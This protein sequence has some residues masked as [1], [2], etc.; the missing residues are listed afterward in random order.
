MRKPKGF[1]L[2]ELLVVIAVIVLLMALL[3]PTLQQVRKEA[4]GVL[5]RS[6]LYEWGF[7][8]SMYAGDHNDRFFDDG[9]VVI[10][11]L[12]DINDVR[13]CPMAM[14]HKDRADDPWALAGV[15][16]RFGGKFSAWTH[17]YPGRATI[18]H[19]YGINDWIRDTRHEYFW[20]TPGAKNT[21]NAPVY[22]DCAGPGA[23][24]FA[25][26]APPQYDDAIGSG[27]SYFCINRH[28]GGINSLFMD[29]S[30]RKIGLKELWTLK[31]HRR[32]YTAGPWTKAGGV[33]PEDWPHWMQ[34]FKD[35]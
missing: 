14:K 21:A 35:Y 3:L 10:G 23:G 13:L 18:Y 2:I 8:F 34:R 29:W 31:W 20:R 7:A 15:H 28:D 9:G 32:F 22:L 1:T 30:V 16:S 5:C 19:S 27:M 24:P 17:S 6:N 26:N 11:Y 25:Y 12:Y 33:Q 4:K